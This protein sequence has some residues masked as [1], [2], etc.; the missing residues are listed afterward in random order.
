MKVVILGAFGK[1]ARLV[2]SR[3]LSESDTDMIWY[4]RHASRLTNPDPKRV[5]IVEGNVNDTDKLT[6]VFHG[7]D[8]VYANLGGNFESK[9][10]SVKKAMKADDVKRLIWVTGLGIYHEL[11]EK[12][13][14]WNEGLIGQSVMD[15]TRRA[16][17]LLETS[18]LN[19]TIIRAAYMNNSPKV[20]YELTQKG[21]EFRGTIISRASI[22]DLIVKII[23]TPSLYE[24]S[25]LGIAQPNTDGDKPV[26]Y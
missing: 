3:L 13:E 22:A 8:I 14:K 17:Q 18:D 5:E 9:A 25:S 26:G 12:F 7:A 6:E 1:I 15:D 21:Q 24:N 11:P 20:D 19:V 10:K 16:A 4:L 2:E 23:K